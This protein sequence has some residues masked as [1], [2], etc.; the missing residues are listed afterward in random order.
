MGRCSWGFQMTT[1]EG[2]H[3][4]RQE[5]PPLGQL[6]AE[7]SSFYQLVS[8]FFPETSSEPSLD[9]HLLDTLFYLPDNSLAY[10][11]RVYNH[12]F[13]IQEEDW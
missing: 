7:E 12:L 10:I 3:V 9:I 11:Y 4:S 1:T 13:R 2:T 6:T 8:L 5:A